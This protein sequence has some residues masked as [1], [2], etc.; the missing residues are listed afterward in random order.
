MKN[1][2]GQQELTKIPESP[3]QAG[4]ARYTGTMTGAT[5]TIT[6]KS[7]S[8]TGNDSAQTLATT[9]RPFHRK[10]GQNDLLMT[11]NDGK[12][13]I[14]ARNPSKWLSIVLPCY[15]QPAKATRNE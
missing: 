2:D 4:L 12:R 8:L 5:S 9:A 3:A 15:P 7:D 11:K 10:K 1:N 6:A 13:R 14:K